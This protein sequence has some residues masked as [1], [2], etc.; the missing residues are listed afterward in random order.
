MIALT[1]SWLRQIGLLGSVAL[2]L[3]DEIHLLGDRRGAS[4]EA[5]ISRMKTVTKNPAVAGK[6][7]SKLRFI[8]ISAT[9]LILPLH[10]PHSATCLYTSVLTLTRC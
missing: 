8:G 9:V 7:A 5:S 1:R 10:F 6:P 4:L 3:V 2:V